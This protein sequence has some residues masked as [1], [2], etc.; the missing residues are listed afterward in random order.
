MEQVLAQ[1]P[2]PE[3]EGLITWHEVAY[4][5]LFSIVLIV[6]FLALYAVVVGVLFSAMG[7][8][9]MPGI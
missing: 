6:L 2:P 8:G 1:A 5:A 7:L 3:A 4:F 9:G